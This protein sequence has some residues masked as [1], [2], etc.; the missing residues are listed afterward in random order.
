MDTQ[1]FVI[2]WGGRG[3][4]LPALGELWAY[5]SITAAFAERN[6]RIKYNK[7]AALGIAWVVIQPVVFMAIFTLTIGRLAGVSGGVVDYAAFTL[8]ALV[9]WTFLSTAV[10]FGANPLIADGALIRKVYFPT[11]DPGPRID[12]RGCGR[13]PHRVG[14]VLHHRA[15]PRAQDVSHT[16]FPSKITQLAASD[17]DLT[18]REN[19]WSYGPICGMSKASPPEREAVW[20]VLSS[21][22]S[23]LSSAT[24]V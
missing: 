21:P 20:Q 10:S 24:P 5:R 23:S 17:P 13:L 19:M 7:Q 14:S 2:E 12:P 11:G 4:L 3:R 16:T 6:I 22:T 8:S 18:G 1:E 15:H 9:A